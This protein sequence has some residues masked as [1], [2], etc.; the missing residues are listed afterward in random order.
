M[1]A[2]V[3]LVLVVRDPVR[4]LISDYHHMKSNIRR[5]AN[6]QK[7]ALLHSPYVN[8]P[9]RKMDHV[10][11]AN[12][13]SDNQGDRMVNRN[14]KSSH[15]NTSEFDLSLETAYHMRGN[16]EL[17]GLIQPNRSVMEEVVNYKQK[18]FVL[19]LVEPRFKSDK[20]DLL[21]RRRYK[22]DHSLRPFEN[23]VIDDVTGQVNTFFRPVQEGVYGHY[24]RRWLEYF[25]LEQIHIVDGE[26]LVTDP[27]FE[28][29]RIEGFLGLKSYFSE[30]HLKF[31][32]SK[33]Y[34][35]RVL[36]ERVKCINPFKGH[37]R[38][39]EK[40][41]VLR[42]LKDYYKPYNLDFFNLTK[43]FFNWGQS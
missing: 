8:Y 43:T 17:L 31:V 29:R 11:T 5:Y 10:G 4:R 19:D 42:K 25:P 24:L 30:K 34:F 6:M 36:G 39:A 14:D 41:T 38:P 15:Q 16:K 2:S 9:P 13:S 22:T 28:L 27:V 7:K 3:L 18:S 20:M 32:P 12:V 35:C 23:E 33:G 40:Q 1:N 37:T 26:K 21:W